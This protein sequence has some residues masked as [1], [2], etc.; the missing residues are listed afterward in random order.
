MI[1]KNIAKLVKKSGCAV[2]W[3]DETR[4]VQW[5]SNGS[6]CWALF[7]MPM[8]D[9]DNVLTALDIPEK[10]REKIIVSELDEAPAA[11]DFGDMVDGEEQLK[12]PVL[13]LS[14]GGSLLLPLTT[15]EGLI[16]ADPDLFQPLRDDDQLTVHVRQDTEGG[17]YLAVKGGMLLQAIVMPKNL[18]AYRALPEILHTLAVGLEDSLAKLAA[19]PGEDKDQMAIDPETGEVIED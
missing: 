14:Y 13:S 18:N 12:D 4:A 11:L 15:A 7:G 1:I 9:G 5:I 19:A 8:L 3:M 6:A 2:L 17:R 10:D 16:L